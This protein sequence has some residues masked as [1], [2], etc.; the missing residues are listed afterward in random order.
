MGYFNKKLKGYGIPRAP[1][2]ALVLMHRPYWHAKS[3]IALGGVGGGE[4]V[5]WPRMNEAIKQRVN[6]GATCITHQYQ[7]LREPLMP[8]QDPW[9]GVPRG[10]V[11]AH[12]FLLNG[13][14]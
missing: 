10:M 9:P 8:T 3:N 13:S 2:W 7:Q 14:C 4:I 5:Y 6:K 11:A 1:Q 12:L